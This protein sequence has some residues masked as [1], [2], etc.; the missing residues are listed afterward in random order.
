MLHNKGYYGED[1]SGYATSLAFISIDNHILC[2]DIVF[3]N[4]KF[5]DN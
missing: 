5:V 3:F 2:N 4:E 1:L